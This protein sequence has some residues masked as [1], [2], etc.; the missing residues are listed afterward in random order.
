MQTKAAT[1]VLGKYYREPK[2]SGPLPFHLIGSLANSLK[3]DHFV[4]D[5]GEVVYY[6]TDPRVGGNL[7]KMVDEAKSC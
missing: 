1:P 4:S 3:E 2:K 5:T 6:Q 7:E